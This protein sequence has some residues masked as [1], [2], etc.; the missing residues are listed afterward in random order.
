VCFTDPSAVSD[1]PITENSMKIKGKAVIDGKEQDVEIEVDLK[2]LNLLTK[3]EIASTH[4]LKE[5]FDGELDRRVKGI[6]KDLVKLGDIGTNAE[7]KKKAYDILGVTVG[8]DGKPKVTVDQMQSLQE[9]WRT[10][11]LKPV[12]EQLAKATQRV[13]SLIGG[14]LDSEIL[15]AAA[16]AGIKKAFRTQVS[17][18]QAA[19]IVTMLRGMFGYSEEHARHF[20]KKG[21]GFEF[22][23]DPKGSGAPYRGA[24]EFLTE[25]AKKPENVDFIDAKKPGGANLGGTGG[26]GGTGGRVKLDLPTDRPLTLQEYQAAQEEAGDNGSVAV[27]DGS[28]FTQA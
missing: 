28:F 10:T 22:S 4:M 6:T 25:W 15:A 16:D 26:T 7:L 9:G 13:N 19:P 11:E 23:A 20:E 8:E 12:Q 1:E 3:E 24:R 27:N 5:T 2:A 14:Q 18:D 21:D 17:K